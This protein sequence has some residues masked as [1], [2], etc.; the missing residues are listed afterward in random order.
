MVVSFTSNIALAKPSE[1]ELASNWVNGTQLQS[2]NNLI[3]ID[4]MDV[5]LTSYT[6]VLNAQTT[7][8]GVG[9]G[10]V[11]GEYVDIQG[12]I[13][14]NF[15]VDFLTPGIIVGSGEY[16]ISLPFPADGAFHIVGTAFNNTVGTASCIGEGYIFD[17]SAVGLSG[18]CALDVVTVAGVS[19][20]RIVL[21]QFVTIAKTSNLY[22]DNMPS[23]V[24]TLDRWTGQFF[25][26]RT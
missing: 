20:A 1:A 14:G 11:R 4:K 15:I 8:P 25:Y 21:E 6:P 5:N 9:A 23:T 24:G 17:N 7:A 3:I 19:Y 10:T 16:G 18:T 22:R 2:D 13:S 26:K 12:F